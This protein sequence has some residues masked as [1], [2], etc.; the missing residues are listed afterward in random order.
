MKKL[1]PYENQMM[2]LVG[3][4]RLP[5]T[6]GERELEHKCNP[7]PNDWIDGIYD[8]NKLPLSVIMRKGLVTQAEEE[9]RKG[10]YGY[11]SDL[12]PS[13][14]GFDAPCFADMITEPIDKFNAPHFPDD[15]KKKAATHVRA[16]ALN[17]CYL[18]HQSAEKDDDGIS[19][20]VFSH[21]NY[22][23]LLIRQ[24]CH[25]I[26]RYSLRLGFLLRCLCCLRSLLAVV[27][28]EKSED[29]H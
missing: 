22:I 1:E 9:R 5:S 24:L 15:E 3:G 23:L 26:A 4:S 10:R 2:Y 18:Y 25:Y 13:Y 6:P 28:H 7:H 27:E 16:T 11:L 29:R 14:G 12:I 17:L 8:F 19:H 20:H 21:A